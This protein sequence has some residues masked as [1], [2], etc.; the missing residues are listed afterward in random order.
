M[1]LL[2]LRVRQRVL[3]SHGINA[4]NIP[5]FHTSFTSEMCPFAGIEME[6]LQMEYLQMKYFRETGVYVSNIYSNHILQNTPV[7]YC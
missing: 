1:H 6:Y 2:L 4:S 3:E 7:M 5:G